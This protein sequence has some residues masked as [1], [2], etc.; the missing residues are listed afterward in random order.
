MEKIINIT[1]DGPSGSGKTS[2]A[3]A[4]AEKLSIAYLDTGAM[5]RGVAYYMQE[6]GI[7]VNNEDDVKKVLKDVNLEVKRENG[8]Q[9]IYVNNKD[10]TSLIRTPEI[11]MGASTVSKIP[12]VRLKLVEL[13]RKIARES[14][15][16][17]DGRDIGSFVL[18]DAEFKFYLTADVNERA[19]RRYL[20]LK[21]KSDV[22][23]EEVKK[24]MIARDEQDASRAFA[25]L[26]VPTG[27]FV[28]DTTNLKFEEVFELILSK[29]KM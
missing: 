1:L 19:K 16:I 27:A 9:K 13:Q 28:I 15:C 26:C 3:K 10:V 2:I 29:I 25:P 22:T 4:V 20:E 23:L 18:P 7:D 14:S 11:S 5:Y 6:K 24:D 17:L 12:D 8:E 21:D